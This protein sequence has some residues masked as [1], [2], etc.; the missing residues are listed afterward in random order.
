MTSRYFVA[1]CIGIRYLAIGLP[2]CG[3]GFTPV[4]AERRIQVAEGLRIRLFASEPQVRQ[5]ILV[6]V[7][8][9]GRL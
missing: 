8:D 2:L 3:Q 1:L 5:P 6:K 7:D 4:E 9:R